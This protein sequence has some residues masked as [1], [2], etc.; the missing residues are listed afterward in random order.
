[1]VTNFAIYT[2]DE[3]FQL[4]HATKKR[5][6]NVRQYMK[7]NVRLLTAMG[8]HALRFQQKNVNMKL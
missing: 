8:I 6:E 4:S 1:M 7:K 5:K 3:F 2:K